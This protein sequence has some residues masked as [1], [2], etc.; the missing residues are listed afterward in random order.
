M[1]K[2]IRIV[3]ILTLVSLV[4]LGTV[5]CNPLGTTAQTSI[6][7]VKVV[8]GDLTSSVT[9]SGNI[10]APREV[11]LTFGSSGKVER[12]LVKAGDKVNKGDTLAKLDTSAVELARKQTEVALNQAKLALTQANLAQQTAERNLQKARDSRDTL[13]LAVLRA[14][15]DFDSANYTLKQALN[16]YRWPEVEVA[17]ADVDKAKSFLNYAKNGLSAAATAEE[18]D[19]GGNVVLMAQGQLDAA[20]AKLDAMLHS[21]DTDEVAMAKLRV[22]AAEMARVQ[23]DKNLQELDGDIAISEL[24]AESAKQATE[25]AQKSVELAQQSLDQ[26]QKQLNEATATAPFDGIVSKVGAEEGE[27]ISALNAIV[28]LVDTSG[29]E[30][31]V[32]VDEMDIPSVMVG[33]EVEISVDAIPDSKFAG[34]VATIHPVPTT[35]GGVVLYQVKIVFQNPPESNLRV[36]MSASADMIIGKRTNIL[37]VPNRAV[38]YDNQGKPVV[39]VLANGQTQTRSVVT[40]ISDDLQTEIVSG[41]AEGETI[42]IEIKSSTGTSGGFLSGG[43]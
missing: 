32:D 12:V 16:T 28:T 1:G 8:R 31:V 10:A 42:V 4:L 36:G 2:K 39:K 34:K 22:K 18:V 9:G 29:L 19:K 37:L 24:Q 30:L 6:Q 40:G 21:Y 7:Y 20:Q 3:L 27:F 26:A 25:Q 17:Q 35:A 15:I 14:Q 23:A 11:S 38:S 33:Q 43:Q 41:L 13:E 5:A